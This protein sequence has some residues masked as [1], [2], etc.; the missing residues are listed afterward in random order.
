MYQIFIGSLVLSTIHALIP[1]HWLPLIAVGRT[2]KWTRNQTLWAAVITGFAHTMSTIL[3]GII[4]GLIGYK[5][6]SRY[7]T[8]SETIAPAILIGLGLIYII[9]DLRSL[10]LHTHEAEPVVTEPGKLKSRW[11]AILTSLSIAMFLTPCIEIEAYYFQAGTIGWIGI[12]IVS[13]VYLMITVAVMLTL[14][15]LGIKGANTFKSDFLE[16]HEKGI[17]GAVLVALGILALLVKF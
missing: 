16:H 14:V 12:F 15:Y 11:I 9:H 10:H 4:V 13:A 2:E 5:L 3:I 17:T 1:N 6:A 7:S 8:I